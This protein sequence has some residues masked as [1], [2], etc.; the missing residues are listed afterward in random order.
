M[1][2]TAAKLYCLWAGAAIGGSVW[3][4]GLVPE[5]IT[6]LLV[7]GFI[8]LQF[9]LRGRLVRALSTRPPL[10][11]FVVL[12][13]ALAAV[14]EGFHMI[15]VPVFENLR[16][17]DETSP[18]Q[19]MARYGLDLLFTLPAYVVIFSVIGWF[20]RRYRYAF[21]EYLAIA[22]FAQT[23]G[24]GGLFYFAHAP[25]MLLFLPYPMS[26]YHAVNV[27]PFLAL[28][29]R[30]E[31]GESAGLARLML[32]PAVVATYLVCGAVIRLAGRLSGIV[33]G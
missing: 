22:G 30:G 10:L 1:P 2:G 7:M 20:A 9:V 11:Q 24:D 3:L 5:T 26:N 32:V 21:W 6:R 15:S 17:G 8:V 13:M 16:I 19:A 27:L 18:A 25:A 4:A 23:I 31:I 28:R 14:V 29:T 12:G 33:D